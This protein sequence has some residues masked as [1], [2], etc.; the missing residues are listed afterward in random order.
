LRS[1]EQRTDTFRR[2][3]RKDLLHGVI[4]L[5]R[6]SDVRMGGMSRRT[7]F[8]F[9]K[10]CGTSSLKNI[11]IATT[12]WNKVTSKEGEERETELFTNFFKSALDEGAKM[13]RHDDTKA[14][15]H[16]ILSTFLDKTSITLKIQKEMV[17]RR[18]TVYLT[19]AGIQVK[20]NLAE[21]LN[22]VIDG[23]R[24][25]MAAAG[26]SEEQIDKAIRDIET[27]MTDG[28]ASDSKQKLGRYLADL[29]KVLDSTSDAVPS[30]LSKVWTA[31]A[32]LPTQLGTMLSLEEETHADPGLPLEARISSNK[33]TPPGVG[34]LPNVTAPST[35]TAGTSSV[36]ALNKTAS[37]VASG[38]ELMDDTSED[39]EDSK[40]RSGAIRRHDSPGDL[41]L[42]GVTSQKSSLE[43]KTAGTSGPKAPDQS[44]ARVEGSVEAV[45]DKRPWWRRIWCF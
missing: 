44:L 45:A 15:A 1:S 13:D 19:D 17:D 7:F 40:S 3:N 25:E 26:Q 24:A 34:P 27:F 28:I 4:Y 11:V 43:E 32:A 41:P 22:K 18:K 8:L 36:E 29:V 39:R 38:E 23:L 12:M 37:L 16:R 35:S 20:Y 6:I 2:Y 31:G 30:L 10:L 5:H 42:H 33:R 14:S 21:R 9:R